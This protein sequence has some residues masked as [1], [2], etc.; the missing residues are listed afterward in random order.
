MNHLMHWQVLFSG[1]N[2]QCQNTFYPFCG[3]NEEL[4]T[5][6]Q[7]M[8]EASKVLLL[9]L[10]SFKLFLSSHCT[11]KQS[12]KNPRIS[13]CQKNKIKKIPRYDLRY[14]ALLFNLYDIFDIARS[15]L[16]CR[17][18]QL[19]TCICQYMKSCSTLSCY[20]TSV[21]FA[22]TRIGIKKTRH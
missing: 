21:Q 2:G 20:R 22:L 8:L 5:F 10:I 19:L 11:K 6:V 14:H 16:S 7:D 3:V 1:E 15:T 4:K 13:F 12:L 18:I 9:V 17:R